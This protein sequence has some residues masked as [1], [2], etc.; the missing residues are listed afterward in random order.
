MYFLFALISVMHMDVRMSRAQQ[1]TTTEELNL[2]VRALVAGQVSAF[3]ATRRLVVA[4]IPAQL[5][6]IQGFDGAAV[7]VEHAQAEVRAVEQSG[8]QLVHVMS[9][10]W[11]RFVF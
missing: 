9:S 2:A 6:L 1:A 11:R 5:F 7:G 10:M 3:T 8:Y 4:E